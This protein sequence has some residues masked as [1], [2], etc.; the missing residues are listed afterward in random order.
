MI[1][2]ENEIF[3]EVSAFVEAGYPGVFFTSEYV[4]APSSF[5]A[6]S[7]VEVDNSVLE[8][9]RASSKTENHASV[10]YE[11]NVY[12][13]KMFGKKAECRSVMALID[14]RMAQLGFTRTMMNA[15]PDLYDATIYRMV[16]RYRA[17]ISSDHIIFRN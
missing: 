2:I 7:L 12:S 9:T 4:K 8:R 17:V 16:A 6:A 15:V 14:E 10:L 11:A 1:D 3:S 13:N 5:P